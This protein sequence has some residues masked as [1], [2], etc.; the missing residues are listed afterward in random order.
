I[1]R[2][3]DPLYVP[4]HRD[5]Y[6]GWESALNIL[7]IDDIHIE[8][9]AR[10]LQE[11]V[12]SIPGRLASVGA[13]QEALQEYASIDPGDL[14]PDQQ[15]WVRMQ[16]GW[17]HWQTG[18]AEQAEAIWSAL[19]ADTSLSDRWR[20]LAA[21]RLTPLIQVGTDWAPL[22]E[23]FQQVDWQQIPTDLRLILY[24]HLCDRR[25]RELPRWQGDADVMVA[26]LQA[27]FVWMQQWAELLHIDL[28]QL[29]VT[30]YAS[31]ITK[32]IKDLDNDLLLEALRPDLERLHP[33]LP[34]L[35]VWENESTGA[36]LAL[37]NRPGGLPRPVEAVSP[38]LPTGQ[39]RVRTLQVREPSLRNAAARQDL[40][41]ALAADIPGEALLDLLAW[42][43]ELPGSFGSTPADK[44]MITAV[45][46]CGLQ[47]RDRTPAL[48][49]AA[50][51]HIQSLGRAEDQ[52]R[53]EALLAGHEL[54]AHAPDWQQ[55][56]AWDLRGQ[57]ERARASYQ[58]TA[59]IDTLVQELVAWRLRRFAE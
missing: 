53:L 45:V 25:H 7:E 43:R 19:L 22:R 34:L 36:P 23:R 39:P 35:T 50:R 4:E 48:L 42:Y 13:Y 3:Q 8:Q 16:I 52:E 29:P 2:Y 33:D 17:C 40:E 56:L 41:Q 27:L 38:L 37:T 47:R 11:H 54:P 58:Q 21:F 10:P 30:Q 57:L 32:R 6:M 18:Q 9:L 55:A 1:V 28:R 51:E 44:A 31:S 12:L 24:N 46:H 49:Q 14:E 20:W 59:A 15:T 26:R 5:C